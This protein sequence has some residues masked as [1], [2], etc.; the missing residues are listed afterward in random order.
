M[1]FSDNKAADTSKLLEDIE[2]FSRQGPVVTK[3]PAKPEIHR[4]VLAFPDLNVPHHEKPKVQSPVKPAPNLG[5]EMRREAPLENSLLARLKQ[6]AESLQKDSGQRTAEQEAR[7]Q[8]ISDAIG[9]AFHYL[10]DLIKQ[11]NIIKPAIPKEFVFPG[12]ILF[13]DMTWLEGA[14]DFRMV[15]SASDDRRYEGLTTRFRI[16]SGKNLVIDREMTTV[17]PFRKLLHDYSIVFTA[18]EKMNTRNIVERARFTFPCEI[19]AGFV[20]KAD[21]EMGNLV[22]RTRNIDRFGMMEFKLQPDDIRQETLDEL[23]KLFLGEKSRFLQ[24]FRRSA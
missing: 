24:L 2:A 21:Y 16:A 20:L 14:T 5:E 10:D 9:A 19:K 6:Q 18:D 11:L 3:E 1:N 22:L 12:N 23:T 13:A 7:A 8:T 15:P 17:E 4:D